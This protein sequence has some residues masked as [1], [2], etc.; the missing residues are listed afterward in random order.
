[1][2]ILALASVLLL[3]GCAMSPRPAQTVLKGAESKVMSEREERRPIESTM[4]IRAQL[5]APVVP[6]A[7]IYHVQIVL[8]A[9]QP[10]VAA[11]RTDAAP[12]AP[13]DGGQ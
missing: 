13:K 8:P 5:P 4:H 1:M 12:E 9:P 2:R 6:P 10:P 3:G 7:A 11:P